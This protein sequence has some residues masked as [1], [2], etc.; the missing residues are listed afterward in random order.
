MLPAAAARLEQGKT[1][2]ERRCCQTCRSSRETKPYRNQ[3]CRFLWCLWNTGKTTAVRRAVSRR[4]FGEGCEPSSATRGSVRPGSSPAGPGPGP[5]GGPARELPGL[6]R[7]A[8]HRLQPPRPRAIMSWD[9]KPPPC[10]G[11][12]AYKGE[13]QGG[14]GGGGGR[15]YSW[16]KA[17]PGSGADSPAP[18]GKAGWLRCQRRAFHTVQASSNWSGNGFTACPTCFPAVD[19]IVTLYTEYHHPSWHLRCCQVQ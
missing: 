12:A 3:P 10:L 2:W 11:F 5:P 18:A 13:G 15:R 7:A 19:G 8:A 17:R 9:R 1:G 6:S 16:A 14:G 4:T